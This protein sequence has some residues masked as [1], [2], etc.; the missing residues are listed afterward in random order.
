MK[1][2]LKTGLFGIIFN[3]NTNCTGITNQLKMIAIADSVIPFVNIHNDTN[4][5]KN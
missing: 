4:S 5:F 1:Q 3:T 2:I